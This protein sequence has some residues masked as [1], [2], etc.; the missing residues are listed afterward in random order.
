MTPCQTEDDGYTATKIA[1]SR[2]AVAVLE[3]ELAERDLA[4][5][6]QSAGAGYD[7][8]MN[9][10]FMATGQLIVASWEACK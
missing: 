1:L 5:L 4:L 9:E 2:R 6:A 8:A 7:R 3:L 10:Q